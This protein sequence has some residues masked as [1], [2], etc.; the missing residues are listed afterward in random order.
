MIFLAGPRGTG[1]TQLALSLAWSWLHQQNGPRS[2]IYV[3]AEKMI[4]Q[5]QEAIGDGAKSAALE[6]Y[7][8]ADLL[9]IDEEDR[10]IRSES[11]DRTFG[12]LWDARY[13][14]RK[15]TLV[16]SNRSTVEEIQQAIGESAYSRLC[17][18]GGIAWCKWGNFR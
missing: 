8:R 5:I 9:I 1:K 4:R 6:R 10:R 13:Q 11:A 3:V 14:F 17:E 2:F 7:A 12:E 15:T 16:I 18:A